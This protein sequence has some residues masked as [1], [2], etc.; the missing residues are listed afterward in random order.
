[1]YTMSVRSP[2][3]VSGDATRPRRPSSTGRLSPV[4]AASATS[5]V[6]ALDDPAVGR[7]HV[8]GLD[9]HD[10]AG[11]ELLGRQLGHRAVAADLGLDEH[12][13]LQGGDGGRRL[14]LLAQAD[15]GVEQ[16]QARG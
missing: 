1:M 6:A 7:H 13:L 9:G 14:A 10:V 5:S 2:S 15:H 4:S 16:R 11:D 12:H 3:G 8:A